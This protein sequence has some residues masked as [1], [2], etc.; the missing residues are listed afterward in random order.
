MVSNISGATTLSM[1]TLSITTISKMVLSIKAVAL[2]YIKCDTQHKS[3]ALLCCVVFA[4]CH[5]AE[6]RYA[7]SRDAILCNRDRLVDSV[8]HCRIYGRNFQ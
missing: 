3:R 8:M 7:E 2:Q 4:E 6:C 1:M 5:Y